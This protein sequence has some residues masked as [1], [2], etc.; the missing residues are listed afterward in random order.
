[1]VYPV[2]DLFSSIGDVILA[3]T[4]CIFSRWRIYPDGFELFDIVLVK[5]GSQG[6]ICRR[7]G[8]RP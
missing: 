2:F 1:M 5:W 4:K 8:N 6:F 7:K 3:G